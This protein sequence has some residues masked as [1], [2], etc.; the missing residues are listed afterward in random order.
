MKDFIKMNMMSKIHWNTAQKIVVL[1]GYQQKDSF[2]CGTLLVAHAKE[3]IHFL[4]GRNNIEE[5]ESAIGTNE[6]VQN[7]IYKYA[8]ALRHA[9]T[10]LLFNVFLYQCDHKE[11]GYLMRNNPYNIIWGKNK[12]LCDF[13]D[14]HI[15]QSHLKFLDKKSFNNTTLESFQKM[16]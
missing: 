6:I 8:Y 5:F 7:N 11:N 9:I 4:F 1:G 16:T 2:N 12:T 14:H 15:L 3:I 10:C 13:Y